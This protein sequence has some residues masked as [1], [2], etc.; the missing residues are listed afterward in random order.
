MEAS[1]PE[2][3]AAHGA[4]LADSIRDQQRI[5]HNITIVGPNLGIRKRSHCTRADGSGRAQASGRDGTCAGTAA[6]RTE[7]PN[8]I[9][10][11]R[12]AVGPVAKETPTGSGFV[13]PRKIAHL[14]VHS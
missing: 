5:A 10:A 1:I 8:S 9:G 3:V 13:G 4:K 12:L 2:D 11:D 14:V 6:T 7:A